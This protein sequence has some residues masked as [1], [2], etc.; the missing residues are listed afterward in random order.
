MGRT[1]ATYRNHLDSLIESFEPF[2]KAL[3]RENQ[4]DMDS[5]WEKAHSYAHAAAYMNPERPGLP[6]VVSMILGVQSEVRENREEIEQ[7]KEQI[8]NV[9]S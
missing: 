3:R 5:L 9:Q 7:L 4:G 6:A 1:N 8:E 2:R